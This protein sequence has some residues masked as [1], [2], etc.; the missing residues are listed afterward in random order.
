MTSIR[1]NESSTKILNLHHDN[2]DDIY[3]QII[4]C[5]KIIMLTGAGI[6]CNAGIP[7]FRSING[8]YNLIPNSSSSIKGKD[9]FDI[10]LFNSI[11]TITDFAKF[12]SNLYL[13][14]QKAKPTKTHKFIEKI[15]NQ[16]KLIRCYTQNIDGLESQLGLSLDFNEH[17]DSTHL[18]TWK[19]LNVI[20]LHG[21]LNSLI[22]TAC[23]EKLNWSMEYIQQMQM[24][25]LPECPQCIHKTNLRISQ[26]KRNTGIQGRLRPNIVLYGENH[27]FSD[28]ITTGLN[29]DLKT[30]P[31]LFIIMGTSLKVHGVKN[32]VKS[33]SSI[34][35]QRGGK[36]LLINKDFIS[37]WNN[38]I[39]YQ[40][41]N[42]CDEFIENFENFEKIYKTSQF[43]TPPSTPKRKTRII[44]LL[45]TPSPQ[46]KRKLTIYND[47]DDDTKLKQ[48][49]ILISPE[50]SPN[51]KSPRIPLKNFDYNIDNKNKI[52]NLPPLHD[53]S[54]LRRSPRIKRIQN[55]LN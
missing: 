11:N 49:N 2:L 34:I 8:L 43:K 31:D 12:M 25:E 36:I 37:G 35:H 45:N 33:M 14:T 20:Q 27:P 13:E 52:K 53:F 22:C 32:L 5:K 41:L 3:T 38:I 4:N 23:F 17:N 6:S 55:L 50:E 46:K 1:N 47:N 42:D 30:K 7:D 10:S 26:G 44:D 15:N 28:I 9:L 16:K 40:I 54:D 39:D 48:R 18:K 29:S 51:K 24:G 21:D 19:K